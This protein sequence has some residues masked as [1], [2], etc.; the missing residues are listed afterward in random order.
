M[1]TLALLLLGLCF[2]SFVNAFV[3]RL[4]QQSKTGGKKSKATG[5]QRSAQ[6]SIL[7]GRSMCPHCRHGLAAR[8]LVPVL[9]WLSLKGKCRYCGKP[10]SW[11]YPLV[12]TFTATL[13]VLSYVFWPYGF[14]AAGML[15]FAVWLIVLTGFVALIVY[16]LR[17]MLL[18]NRIVYPL[19]G[20]VLFQILVLSIVSGSGV[21]VIV[22]ATWGLVFSGGIFYVL[23]QISQGR[24][25]GGGDVKL[26][27]LLGLLVG[28]PAKSL[29]MLFLASFLGTLVATPL[30]LSGKATRKTRIPFGPFLIIA[31]II[32][33]LF[34]PRLISWY[35]RSLG[36]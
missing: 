36:L 6:Y 5:E 7:R 18:P 17:W 32:V 24:W 29:L 19:I 33:Q 31:A 3:W 20:L 26:G 25:I 21:A 1:I 12:E 35:Y 9:S 15:Q 28:G 2:G 10:V 4:H 27:F 30:L 34:G 8:D 22:E 16:D 23:F 13:F 11:Q 14:E